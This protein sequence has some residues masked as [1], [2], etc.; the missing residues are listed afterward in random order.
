[1]VQNPFNGI[2]RHVLNFSRTVAVL[3]SMNPFNG[4]ESLA[5]EA[6]RVAGKDCKYEESVQWN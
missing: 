4:I 2:E 6:C 5:L 1:M 3:F